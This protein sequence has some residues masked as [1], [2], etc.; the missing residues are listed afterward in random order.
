MYNNEHNK[1]R[2]II[3]T[4]GISRIVEP[5]VDNN[6][7]IGIIECA[8]RKIKESYLFFSFLKK[9]NSFFK[10]KKTLKFYCD[11]KKIPYYY[12]DKGSNEELEYW[13]KKRNP[14]VI[15][16]YS[17]SQLLKPNIFTIPKYGTLNLHPSFLPKYRGP[18]PWF[19]TYYNFEEF[20][21]VTLHYIDKGEDTGDIIYQE[22]YKIRLGLKSPEMQDIAIGKIGNS[23]I[24]KAIANISSLPR[25][26][27]PVKSSTKRAKNIGVNEHQTIIDFD[28]WEIERIWHV[29]RGTE[30]W[31]NSIPQPK[32]FLRNQRWIV[33]EMKI[34][35]IKKYDVGK[36]YKDENKFFLV[37]K[38]GVIY[39]SIKFSI[40]RFLLSFINSYE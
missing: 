18:N 7:V 35:N 25:L 16:V 12:M 24:S 13:V 31:L 27:Q 19:S 9:L 5:L 34:K 17:M 26:K 2:I 38:E 20:G 33:Q 1:V 14:D 8:P 37:C 29:L 36:I 11:K 15:F 40:S 21:G 10:K 3:I 22:Q 30:L 39:L 4:M 28:S 6:E 32:G 23:L